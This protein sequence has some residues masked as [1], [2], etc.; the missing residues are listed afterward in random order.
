[1]LKQK[2]FFEICET[3]CSALITN[4]KFFG[5]TTKKL[6]VSCQGGTGSKKSLKLIDMCYTTR[7]LE[8]VCECCAAIRLLLTVSLT[9]QFG[10]G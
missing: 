8:N 6:R 9:L 3:V 10:N 4:A 2:R 1:M 5:G 7:S